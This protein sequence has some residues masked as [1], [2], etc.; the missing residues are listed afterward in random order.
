MKRYL[1]NIILSLIVLI[2]LITI[3]LFVILTPAVWSDY[4]AAHID[5]LLN[6]QGEWTIR[7]GS[8]NGHL[9]TETVITDFLYYNRDSSQVFAAP[10]MSFNINPIPWLYGEY[11]FRKVTV[12]D[13]TAVYLDTVERLPTERPVFSTDSLL[14]VD[15]YI[16]NFTVSGM[17]DWQLK[18]RS[19]ETGEIGFSGRIRYRPNGSFV[20]AQH[21]RYRD[22]DNRRN[23]TLTDS[24]FQ[25]FP[26]ELIIKSFIGTLNE[27]DFSGDLVARFSPEISLSG[28]LNLEN[29]CWSADSTL[30]TMLWAQWD[31]VDISL[32][33]DSDLK[34]H[35]GRFIVFAGEDSIR[36]DAIITGIA[37]SYQIER[38]ELA[39]GVSRVIGRGIVEPDGRIG[40][41]VELHGFDIS[42]FIKQAPKTNQNGIVL[43]EMTAPGLVRPAVWISLEL[44]DTVLIPD[45]SLTASGTLL[46]RDGLISVDNPVSISLDT[47]NIVIDGWLDWQAKK[48]EIRADLTNIDLTLG[49]GI[50]KINLN[51]GTIS[52][53]LKQE[54]SIRTPLV[55]A[56]L[57]I[58]NLDYQ[59]IRLEQVN[60]L[61]TLRGTP[62]D[63]AGTV[64]LDVA[65]GNWRQY[66][67]KEGFFDISLQ[68]KLI[69]IN[70]AHLK[71]QAN[72]IQMNG[73]IDPSGALHLDQF[74][75]AYN[76]HYFVSTHPIDIGWTENSFNLKPFVVH[77]DDGILEGFFSSAD[78]RE[79]RMRFSNFDSDA[80]LE[81]TPKGFLGL[82]GLLFGEVTMSGL[83]GEEV[84][85]IELSVK[86]GGILNQ[87]FD[88]L[89]VSAVLA[90]SIIH[91]EEFTLT[92]GN[93]VG[94]QL[95]GV[96]PLGSKLTQS[97]PIELFSQLR[98]V[99]FAI[100]HQFM[101]E[102]FYLGGKISGDFNL[103]G[104][105]SDTEFDFNLT[106]ADAI[107]D[108]IPLGT[109]SGRG[110][111]SEQRVDFHQ[112]QSKY[113][114]NSIS[115]NGYLPMDFNIASSR[116]GRMV[117]GDSLYLD[118]AAITEDLVFLSNYLDAA[119]SL[120]GNF[121]IRLTLSGVPEKILRNGQMTV[122]N[123]RV[124]TVLLDNTIENISAGLT[125]TDN[126]L[127]IDRFRGALPPS[128]DFNRRSNLRAALTAQKKSTKQNLTI[129]GGMD[130][131]R[132]FKPH[133]D[134]NLKASNAYIR[135]LLGDIEGLVDADLTMTGREIITY[136]GRIT[137]LNVEM[138]QEFSS[139]EID[140]STHQP[141]SIV[142]VYKLT[143]PI[144]GDFKLVNTQLDADLSGELSLVQYGEEDADY[145]GELF[146]RGGKFYYTGDVFTI[147]EGSSMIFDGRGFNPTMDIAAYTNID[148]YRI[149]VQL[150]GK[151]DN[152][153]L[154]FESDPT[155][156]QSDILQLLTLRRRI[157][158]YDFASTGFGQLPSSIL[159]AWFGQQLEKNL[160]QVTRQLGIIDEVD[161]RTTS[162]AAI[163][164]GTTEDV[165]K[166]TAQ[167]QLSNKLALNY[168]Y[169]YRRSFGLTNPDQQ[170]VG[171][172]YK[173]NRYLSLV[174]NYDETGNLQV[175]Y[176]LRY[177]Y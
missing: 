62:V 87:Q 71:D 11:N 66:S 45:K 6:A 15:I 168:T 141:G 147:I 123:G 151:L 57:V 85:E 23:F 51:G 12:E 10:R 137:P 64:T 98:S 24:G 143:F 55:N 22:S 47:G 65:N 169:S 32:H 162:Q 174:G 119:D 114:G 42:R 122:E 102:F 144:T 27:Q 16:K 109:V 38:I 134:L 99:D 7:Y 96:I 72:F 165:T 34:R 150:T 125:I 93:D 82:S 80:V 149:N 37:D 133:F 95:S 140:E 131:T 106:I 26:E 127:K 74:Q 86:N 92:H 153:T 30:K 8:I 175:K 172:E 67:F 40:G 135:T 155:L 9:L 161:I 154:T 120:K 13:F 105:T 35:T 81:H 115:A 25:L 103:S 18:N 14:N 52:G 129:S 48:S 63:I 79:G 39:A 121:D 171:V 77:I 177:S 70:S 139:S 152:P 94:I 36:G 5:E 176:R 118:V 21:F 111:Y 104:S 156:S 88:D 146:V 160:L 108:I 60:L 124:Y 166:I 126:Q 158:D 173:L 50:G 3:G 97:V 116:F 113:R 4:I 20:F 46:I 130:L 17:I 138:K 58:R 59:G 2:A 128:A 164:N 53:N 132:F 110:S 148:I 90:D 49:N 117:Q 29:Y 84:V 100:I 91:F 68:D 31:T 1:K 61:S 54:G 69:K 167:K 107:F 159:S 76:Q 170:L 28:N 41:R 101:P 33:F 89:V 75:M 163:G 56:N 157:E 73:N 142:T 44:Q 19:R 78:Y 112:L 43:V 145:A 83:A 136:S